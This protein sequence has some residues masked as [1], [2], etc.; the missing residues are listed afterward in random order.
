[1]SGVWQP[2]CTD[3]PGMPGSMNGGTS[4]PGHCTVGSFEIVSLN[5]AGI[6]VVFMTKLIRVLTFWNT[7]STPNKPEGILKYTSREHTGS[8]CLNVHSALP[9]E[10][11]RE[12]RGTCSPSWKI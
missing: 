9:G 7:I 6:K 11:L 12:S 5:V 1:M 3:S 2:G 8:V 4:R 10:L